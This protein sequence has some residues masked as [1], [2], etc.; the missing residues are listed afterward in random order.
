MRSRSWL[1]A[2]VVAIAVQM[3]PMLETVSAQSS[4]GIVLI[5]EFRFRG[6]SS[7]DGGALDEFIELYNPG[8]AEVSLAKWTVWAS[9]ISGGFGLRAT[10]PDTAK[11]A[12]GCHFLIANAGF[13]GTMRRDVTYAS[14]F[15]DTGGVAL[16]NGS[17]IVDQVGLGKGNV[18]GE[19]TQLVQ[20]P[21]VH[22]SYERKPGGALG[23]GQ[24]TN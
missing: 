14:G 13:S 4:P 15:A 17:V 22:S 11:I 6:P 8:P 16:M 7:I 1:F 5:S 9:N 10:L 23:N 24:D 12:A 2:T 18:Y 3:S 19:G 20:L 21:N